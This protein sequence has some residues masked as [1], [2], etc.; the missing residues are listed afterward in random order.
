MTLAIPT[1]IPELAPVTRQTRPDKIKIHL[2][3]PHSR[4]SAAGSG[5][6]FRPQ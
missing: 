1:P 3:T 2:R 5:G 4:H 6:A